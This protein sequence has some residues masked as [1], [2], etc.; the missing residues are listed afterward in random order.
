MPFHQIQD[1]SALFCIEYN[2][3]DKVSAPKILFLLVRTRQS[4]LFLSSSD[5]K[6]KLSSS[7]VTVMTF[8]LINWLTGSSG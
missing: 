3:S 7:P 5:S 6:Y 4:S 1:N 8:S 2:K